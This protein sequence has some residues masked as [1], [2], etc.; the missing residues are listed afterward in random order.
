MH[1]ENKNEPTDAILFGNIFPRSRPW[2]PLNS[3][4]LL[5]KQ[6]YWIVGHCWWGLQPYP[7]AAVDKAWRLAAVAT[8][9][10]DEAGPCQLIYGGQ[11]ISIDLE[12][13]SVC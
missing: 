12:R 10:A 3:L 11:F 4:V 13:A 1:D 2:T 9:R 6:V 7:R 5:S 8:G